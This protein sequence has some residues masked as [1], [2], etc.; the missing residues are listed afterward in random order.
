MFRN[1]QAIEIAEGA[2]LAD[3][4]VAFQFLKTFLPVGGGFFYA[5]NF[6]VFTILVLRRGVYVEL[7]SMCVAIFVM[8]IFVGPYSII[9]LVT[10]GLAGAFLG[11]TLKHRFHYIPIALSGA[12]AGASYIFIL[13]VGVAWLTGIPFDIYINGLHRTYKAAMSLIALTAQR[14]GLEAMWQQNFYPHMV[15]LSQWAFDHW[16][17]AY[18]CLLL[19]FFVPAILGIYAVVNS[20]VRMLGYDVRPMLSGKSR[21]WLQRLRRRIVKLAVKRKTERQRWSNV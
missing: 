6:I 20:F 1:L 15:T 12:L 9:A 2:L 7:L 14:V 5:M 4:A 19:I 16:A 10:Q 21:R 17:L 3:I 11:F 13:T 8:S 18:Y